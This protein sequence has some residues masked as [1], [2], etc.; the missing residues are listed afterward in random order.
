MHR[1]K[2]LFLEWLFWSL[3]DRLPR[4][5]SVLS[6]KKSQFYW[7]K[8]YL[9]GCSIKDRIY[10]S[11]FCYRQPRLRRLLYVNSGNIDQHTEQIIR[12]IDRQ[13]FNNALTC[14]TSGLSVMGVSPICDLCKKLKLVFASI[15]FQK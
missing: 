5:L 14:S 11:Q 8:D 2:K 15:E 7:C 13:C 10:K 9:G 1:G 3:F 4:L 6:P 12:I